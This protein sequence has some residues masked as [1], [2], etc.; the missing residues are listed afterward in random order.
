MHPRFSSNYFDNV[1][2]FSINR[3][4]QRLAAIHIQ[5]SHP[6]GMASEVSLADEISYDSL[7][8]NGGTDVSC[9]PCSRENMHQ[10]FWHN[11]VTQAQGGKYHLTKRTYVDDPTIGVQALQRRNRAAVKSIFAIVVI[12]DNPRLRA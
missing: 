11:Y 1:S 6:A 12:L 10:V 7:I 8:E 4:D 9:I 2:H 5:H 3:V